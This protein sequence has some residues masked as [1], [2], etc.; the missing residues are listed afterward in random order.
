[1]Q[2]TVHSKIS[3]MLCVIITAESV[4]ICKEGGHNDSQV[5]MSKGGCSNN[6]RKH[7]QQY[8]Y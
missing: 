5:H 8:T 7:M 4:G 6:I 3:S 2:L 1:M